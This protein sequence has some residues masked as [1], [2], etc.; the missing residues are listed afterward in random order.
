VTVAIVK[1][2]VVVCGKGPLISVSKLKKRS[3]G[4]GGGRI[5]NCV[6]PE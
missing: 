6:A 5:V 3:G 2:V 4:G 1:T